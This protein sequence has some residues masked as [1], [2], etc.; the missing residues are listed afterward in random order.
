M[1]VSPLARKPS[2]NA[3]SG[4]FPFDVRYSSFDVRCFS[5]EVMVFF[6]TERIFIINCLVVCRLTDAF[7]A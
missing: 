2:V 3:G 7:G 1:R 5:I 6:S 4:R